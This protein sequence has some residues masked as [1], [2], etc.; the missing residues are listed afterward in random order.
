ML[1]WLAGAIPSW[2]AVAAVGVGVPVLLL[3]VSGAP[4]VAPGAD[5]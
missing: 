2:V 1:A 3:W 5:W 4:S